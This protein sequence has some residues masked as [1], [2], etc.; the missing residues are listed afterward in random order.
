MTNSRLKWLNSSMKSLSSKL[1]SVARKLAKFDSSLWL[2]CPPKCPQLD[3]SLTQFGASRPRLR[4]NLQDHKLLIGTVLKGGPTK[5][6]V[7]SAKAAQQS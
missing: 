4:A 2:D 6:E 3:P 5:L 7:C 1:C